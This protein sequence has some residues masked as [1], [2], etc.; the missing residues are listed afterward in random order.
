MHIAGVIVR[1]R[2]QFVP[3]VR[4]SAAGIG[5]VEVHA[6]TDDGRLVVTVEGADRRAVADGLFAL[7]GLPQVLS[8]VMVYEQ[9]EHE[10]SNREASP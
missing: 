5:G 3:E 6:A 2:P 8:A 10:S 7:N 9:S 1:T 4:A